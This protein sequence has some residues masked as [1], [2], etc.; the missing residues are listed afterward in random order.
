VDVTAV[1]DMAGGV[2]VASEEAAISQP[3]QSRGHP[4]RSIAE[5]RDPAE[6]ASQF[7]HGILRLRSE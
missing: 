5:S 6:Y 1:A 7:R 3:R 2:M 4:E